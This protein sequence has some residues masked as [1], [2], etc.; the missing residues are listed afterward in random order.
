MARGSDPRNALAS[1]EQMRDAQDG[2]DVWIRG[3]GRGCCRNAVAG[4]GKDWGYDDGEV[5]RRDFI[6]EAN[7]RTAHILSY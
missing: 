4:S 3:S 2:E 7:Q 6:Y 5:T 1:R